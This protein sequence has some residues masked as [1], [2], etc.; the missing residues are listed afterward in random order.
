MTPPKEGVVMANRKSP[1]SKSTPPD[2]LLRSL[3]PVQVSNGAETD[4]QEE[5]T[6]YLPI[7]IELDADMLADSA[8]LKV[9]MF[10]YEGRSDL[11]HVVRQL[12][13]AASDFQHPP[14]NRRRR[15]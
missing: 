4:T 15:A 8:G 9:Q 11:R 5:D 3:P 2:Q 10:F 1:S 12:L 6:D 7:E 13:Q 14:F